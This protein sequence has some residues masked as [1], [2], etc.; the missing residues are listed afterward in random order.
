M[1]T[2][3]FAIV[4]VSFSFHPSKTLS[5]QQGKEDRMESIHSSYLTD[6]LEL[7]DKEA[8]RFWPVYDEYRANEDQ[9]NKEREDNI[10][11]VRNSGGIDEMSDS[12]VRKLIEN[13]A[14]IRTRR[15]QLD[16]E[17]IVKFETVLTIRK[18]A[19]FYIAEEEFKR[20]LLKKL[21][22]HGR[23]EGPANY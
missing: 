1:R 12:A 17:Y 22:Q 15:L 6:K 18:V 14:D 10:Q 16:K 7:S 2:I 11:W 23:E 8:K 21:R 4:I 20:Y 13:E 19:K 9:L 5:A 3:F